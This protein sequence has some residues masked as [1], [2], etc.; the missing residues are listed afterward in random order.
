MQIL[1]GL[2]SAC[3]SESHLL[4]EVSGGSACP[5]FRVYVSLFDPRESWGKADSDFSWFWLSRKTANFTGAVS[6]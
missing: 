4:V 5:D 2:I 1:C 3:R 6:W